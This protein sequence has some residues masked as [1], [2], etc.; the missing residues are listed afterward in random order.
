VPA[1]AATYNVAAES[2][3]ANSMLSFYKRLLALR[4]REPALRDGLYL[5]LN[6]EDPYVL[7]FLRKRPGNGDAVLVLLNMSAETRTV[8]FDLSAE[9]VKES[10]PKTLIAAPEIGPESTQLAHFTVPAFGVFIGAV[11]CDK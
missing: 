2:Q 8:K 6:L 9:G 7:S 3:D 4:R 5:P 10:S 11:H 1:S